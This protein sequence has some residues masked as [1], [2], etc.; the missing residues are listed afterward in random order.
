MPPYNPTA[1]VKTNQMNKNKPYKVLI[2]KQDLGALNCS[3]N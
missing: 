2:K 3:E 1:C